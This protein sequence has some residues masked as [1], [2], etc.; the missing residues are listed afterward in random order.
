MEPARPPSV[1]DMPYAKRGE[2][3]EGPPPTG[4]PY[5]QTVYRNYPY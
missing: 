5:K 1:I 2:F 3:I 4:P